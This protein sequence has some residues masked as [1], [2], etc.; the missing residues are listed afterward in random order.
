MHLV[1]SSAELLNSRVLVELT[2]REDQ[3][4]VSSSSLLS[5]NASSI[6]LAWR[7]PN[8]PQHAGAVQA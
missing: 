6:T 7:Q 8:R 2:L 5:S 3:G 4:C 1:T